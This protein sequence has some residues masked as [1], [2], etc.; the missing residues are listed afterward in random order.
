MMK[1]IRVILFLLI[2]INVIFLCGCWDMR[3]I[4]EL[5]L[6]TAVGIDKGEGAN[7]YVVTVQIAN[8][9]SDISSDGQGKSKAAVWI[10]SEEGASIFDA[11]RKLVGISSR[12]IMWAHNN[13]VIIGESLAKEGIIPIVDYFTHNPE[14]RL[15]TVVVVANGNAKD[16]V[17]A[18]A[19]MENPSG[20]SFIL[21][22]GYRAITAESVE[23][24]MLEVS[25][26][27]KNEYG[28]P[29]ISRISMKK[30]SM[31]SEGDKG[32]SEKDS[33]TTSL[34]G[35]AVFKKD[36]MIALFLLKTAEGFH[37]FLTKQ[38]IL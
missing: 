14:L 36:K 8:P 12:R 17:A 26:T 27:I 7:R 3:E 11:T 16:Y 20:M 5:G 18:K 9:T 29:R 33:E 13:V 15:K 35:I 22:E 21:L 23:S 4:N 31:Q 25:S 32:G 2:T 1:N 30:A 28:N 19:G 6:V 24:H 34:G 37:G 10:G 38:K